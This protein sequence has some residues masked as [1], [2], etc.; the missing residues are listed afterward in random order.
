MAQLLSALDNAM[1]LGQTHK[2]RVALVISILDD[3]PEGLVGYF[4][5]DASGGIGIVTHISQTGRCRVQYG[6]DGLHKNWLQHNLRL[7]TKAKIKAAG[8]ESTNG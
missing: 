8:Q 7:A 5:V 4:V 3:N 1:A 2:E 6:P